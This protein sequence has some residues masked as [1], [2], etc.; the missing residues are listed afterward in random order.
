MSNAHAS[1]TPHHVGQLA[2][3]RIEVAALLGGAPDPHHLAG[4]IV[5]VL[6][7]LGWT[8]PH[9]PA[10]DQ[11]PLQGPGAPHDGPGRREWAAAPPEP[12]FRDK[13][14]D[15][16]RDLTYR[17]RNMT[18]PEANAYARYIERDVAAEVE[19]RVQAATVAQPAPVAADEAGR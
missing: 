13:L 14:A 5:D 3:A 2:K 9:D 17:G 16:L 19:A 10:A 1:S 6:Q 11:P 18:G 4:R 7:N 15:R 12:R 8:P